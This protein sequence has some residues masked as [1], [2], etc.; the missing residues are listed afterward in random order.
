MKPLKHFCG[1]AAAYILA[2][3]TGMRRG[4]VLGLRWCDVDFAD[5]S[6]TI[7]QTVVS[8][9]YEI[10]IHGPKTA[11]SQRKVALDDQTIA[12]LQFHRARQ[13][14]EREQGDLRFSEEDLAFAR[15]DGAPIHPDYFSQT[16]DRTIIRLGLPKIRLH[17]LRHTYATLALAAGVSVKVVSTRL[18][19]A[20]AA[21]TQDVYMQA[22]EEVER[23]AACSVAAV[24]FGTEPGASRSLGPARTSTS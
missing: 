17:D 20:T 1:L 5:R 9:E 2:A 19:H 12:V 15:I 7:N 10:H 18:G 14:T 4:E 16:F 24:V 21:F 8:V 23:S 22:I 11:G 6:L 3:T 13:L